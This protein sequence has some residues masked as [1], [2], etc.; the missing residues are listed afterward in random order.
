MTIL[1]KNF[2]KF[3]INFLNFNNIMDQSF[4]DTSTPNITKL[5]LLMPTVCEEFEFLIEGDRQ[6]QKKERL[7]V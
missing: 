5:P 3:S 4:A 6:D 2:F 1:L 7:W